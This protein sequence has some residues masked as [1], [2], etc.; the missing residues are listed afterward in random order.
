MAA[1]PKPRKHVPIRTCVACR[2]P[3]DKRG[4]LRVVRMPDGTVVHD[5]G[6]K[7]NGRGAYVCARPACIAVARKRKGLDRGLKVTVPPELYDDLLA[8][9]PAD[10]PPPSPSS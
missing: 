6:G 10:T 7:L 5:P 4:L 1:D 3:G 2:T 9:A 8:H